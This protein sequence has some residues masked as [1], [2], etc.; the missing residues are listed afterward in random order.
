MSAQPTLNA[1]LAGVTAL[2]VGGASG[3]GRAAVAGYRAAGARVTALDRSTAG[4]A[5]LVRELP[6]VRAVVGD[7]TAPDAVEE[8]LRAAES[9]GSPLTQLTHCVGIHD[10]YTVPWDLDAD[11]LRAGFGELFAVNVLSV[12][13][14]VR[15]CVGS[16]RASGG[17]I[18]LTLSESAFAPLGGGPLYAAS[19]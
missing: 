4:C 8:A 19:K 12:V 2:V 18:T 16:L 14:A 6:G 9:D 13:I 1:Q 17:S 15:A 11:A 3:I 5:A 10:R 7:A